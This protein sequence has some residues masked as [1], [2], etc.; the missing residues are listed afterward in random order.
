MK[1]IFFTNKCSHGYELL[2]RVRSEG[3]AI[4]AVFI[5]RKKEWIFKTFLKYQITIF[6]LFL[7]QAKEPWRNDGFYYRY[8]K[9]VF[10]VDDF[11]GEY[12]ESIL[13]RM[14]PD[15][16]VLGGSGII[17]KNI[18]AI[19]KIGII[20]GHPGLL[21]RYRG[22]DVIPWAIYNGDDVGVTIHFVDDGIDTGRIVTQ[23]IIKIERRDNI[24][25]LRRK[26]EVVAARLISKALKEIIEGYRPE[27]TSTQ[28]G[29]EFKLYHRMPHG[30]IKQSELRLQDRIKNLG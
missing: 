19:P 20:N 3:I 7:K 17:K 30:L 25:K 15:I 11:N 14:E 26:A 27:S 22:V 8:A 18:I 1:I 16:I 12:C 4:S 13:K 9:N 21:P 23:E 29:F 10:I 24:G 2:E 5:S 6:R 28:F